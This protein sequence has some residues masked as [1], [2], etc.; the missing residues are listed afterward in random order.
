MVTLDLR[1]TGPDN[2][3]IENLKI[4][5][6]SF[7]ERGPARIDTVKLPVEH[8]DRDLGWRVP[9]SFLRLKVGSGFWAEEKIANHH[10]EQRMGRDL[11]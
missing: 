11:L 8:T 1:L 2:L 5:T 6:N 9:L 3:T 7:S 4:D 10:E